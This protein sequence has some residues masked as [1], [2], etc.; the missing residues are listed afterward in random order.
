[1]SA[2]WFH[3]TFAPKTP[4]GVRPARSERVR[5]ASQSRPASAEYGGAGGGGASASSPVT[6]GS[7]MSAR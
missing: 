1:M 5:C 6:Y 2:S 4:F 3:M 7:P